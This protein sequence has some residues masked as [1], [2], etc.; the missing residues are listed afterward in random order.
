MRPLLCAA[1]A[2]ASPCL[3]RGG[4]AACRAGGDKTSG[5]RPPGRKR[6]DH[7]PQGKTDHSMQ[8]IND[9]A[10]IQYVLDN[11]D[12]VEA[13]PGTK[14]KTVF[15]L[16]AYMSNKRTGDMQTADAKTP[17]LTAK[18]ENAYLLADNIPKQSENVNDPLPSSLTNAAPNSILNP[19]LNAYYN[20]L[21]SAT[22]KAQSS[23]AFPKAPREHG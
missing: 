5:R 2:K 15:I 14:A 10:R 12:S 17:A 7:G 3:S 19:Y 9:I 13:V 11:Y 1:P 20:Y 4:G 8:D 23:N 18:P 21:N 6:K 16:S 22:S